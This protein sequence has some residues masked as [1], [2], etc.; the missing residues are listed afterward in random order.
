MG[1]GTRSH[2]TF[3]DEK[4]NGNFEREKLVDISNVYIHMQICINQ[5]GQECSWQKG[6]LG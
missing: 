3:L 4:M 1:R 6:I 2:C 5:N